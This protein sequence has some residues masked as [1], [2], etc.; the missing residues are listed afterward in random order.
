[1]HIFINAL[2]ARLGG[3]QTYLINL[4][5]H[6]P[7]TSSVRISML[8]STSQ[9]MA[10]IPEGVNVRKS[11]KWLQKPLLRA[12]WERLFLPGV[13]RREKA[14][15]L[16]CPGGVVLTRPPRG[17]RLVTM[18]RNMIPFD[19]K[20]RKRY[21]WGYKRVRNWLL[22]KIMASSL[23]KADLVIFISDYARRVI[24][25]HPKIAVKKSV[26]IPHGISDRFMIP[27]RA[28]ETR[29]VIHEGAYLLYVSS[30]DVYKMQIEVIRAFSR[31]ESGRRGLTLVL[32]GPEI[33]RKYAAR[34]RA[35]VN[36]FGLEEAVKMVGSI[37]Y[38]E[39]PLWY[40][41][42]KINIFAS[43]SEN[44]PNILLEMMASGRPV[45][46]SNYPPMPEFGQDAVAYFD[47]EDPDTL[48]D[49]IDKLLG[50]RSLCEKLSYR[51]V[52]ISR[53]YQWR[54]AARQTWEEIYS[55]VNKDKNTPT[56]ASEASGGRSSAG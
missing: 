32:A 29:T 12:I 53:S 33:N 4:L 6:L 35:E 15:V 28:E 20:Q 51:S 42:A 7:E 31:L 40:Q 2:N 19:I 43:E 34:V 45:A 25:D 8:L 24:E 16:F 1:M 49:V 47:P 39:L 18:F 46:C 9:G 30:V 5:Q 3:G 52:E 26:V 55:L 21:A 10:G 22:Q 48:A 14:D 17:C 50:S 44:C 56:L 37:P 27:S 41:N 11:G 54:D 23:R 38:D 13:L 36:R